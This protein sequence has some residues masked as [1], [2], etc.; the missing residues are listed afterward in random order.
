MNLA[1]RLAMIVSEKLKLRSRSEKPGLLA[2]SGAAYFS[3]LD[4]DE[5][6]LAGQAAVRSAVDGLSGVMITLERQPGRRYSVRDGT[7]PLATVASAER[8]FPA[9]WRN[10]S[11]NDVTSE[12]LDYAA[13][14][15]GEIEHY[16]TL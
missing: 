6:R 10:V 15:I 3:Q 13:P 5:A 14:L 9:E 12:F 16:P 4:W 2:R 7:V 11:G 1:H 8:A